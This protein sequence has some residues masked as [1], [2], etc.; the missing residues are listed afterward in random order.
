MLTVKEMAKEL[1]VHTN[2]VYK[3]IA[4]GDVA[5]IRVGN[6]IR[7]PKEEIDALIRRQTK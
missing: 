4:N 1:R 7:I 6:V 2:T 3:M 5:V